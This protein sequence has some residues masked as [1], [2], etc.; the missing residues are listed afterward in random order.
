MDRILLVEDDKGIRESICRTLNTDYAVETAEDGQ[1]ALERAS[2]RFYDLILLDYKLPD[3]D[4]I[5]VAERLRGKS[6]D[7]SINIY[8]CLRKHGYC[9]TGPEA[10]GL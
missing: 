3:T 5:K 1:Q 2:E 10:W 4:G 9:Y 6:P 8:N 7:V